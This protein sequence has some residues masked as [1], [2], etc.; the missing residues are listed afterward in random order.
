[1]TPHWSRQGLLYLG[2]NGIYFDTTFSCAIC[3]HKL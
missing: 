1:M 2:T 3:M